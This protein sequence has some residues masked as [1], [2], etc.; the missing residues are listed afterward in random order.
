MRTQAEWNVLTHILRATGPTSASTR[1][2]ISSAA[3][4][5][6]VMARMRE[7]ADAVLVDEVGD[8][9]GEHPRLARAGAGD[10]EQR[11]LGVDDGVEL[12]GVEQV[13]ELAGPGG[14]GHRT[15]HPTR[16]V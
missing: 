6:K 5:V 9:M 16:G 11:T 15:A 3:L 1:W 12:V 8:A 13:G 2:R 14:G 10:D 4:L 7:R